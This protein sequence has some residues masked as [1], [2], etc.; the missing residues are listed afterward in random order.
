MVSLLMGNTK[1]EDM[2]VLFSEL[3]AG[4]TIQLNISIDEM[5][6]QF[7]T[8]VFEKHKKKMLVEPIRKDGKILNVQ[9]DNVAVD[10]MYI[11]EDEKPILWANVDIECVRLKG[12]LY[13]A[14][15]ENLQG[16]EYNRRGDF[17]LFIGEEH[18]ARIG[19][20]KRE[21]IVTLK[22]LS[23]SGFA[24]VYKEEIEESDGSFVYMNYPGVL[25]D[26][27]F[28][29]PLIGKIVRKMTLADGRKL[30]GCVLM[31]K[32][33]MIGYYINQKQMEQL[34]KK[35]ERFSNVKK[36]GK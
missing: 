17:R 36:N 20:G 33:E 35:N 3:G 11:R 14:V 10:I 28:E 24:F 23:S 2:A 27:T 31:K 12:R 16:K 8:V 19:H 4:T 1:G 30:Y 7:D 21:K 34:A 32:N 25:S 13:Y 18:P 15:P 5:F 6:F 22:D 26:H 29:L 9:G